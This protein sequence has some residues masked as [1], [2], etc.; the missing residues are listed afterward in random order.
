V[1]ISQRK[2][3]GKGDQCVMIQLAKETQTENIHVITYLTGSARGHWMSQI[4]LVCG[5]MN[6]VSWL[7]GP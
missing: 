4:M 5:W 1:N 6:T 2:Y 3:S 7:P